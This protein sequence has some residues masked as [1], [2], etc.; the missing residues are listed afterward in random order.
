LWHAN[1]R[2]LRFNGGKLDILLLWQSMN[3]K[4]SGKLGKVINRLSP[5]RKIINELFN[6]GNIIKQFPAH[7]STFK[8]VGRGGKFCT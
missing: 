4:L 8:P 2:K 1:S 6:G 7:D 3:S 5:H